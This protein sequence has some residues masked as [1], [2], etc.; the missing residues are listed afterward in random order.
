MRIGGFHRLQVFCYDDF[1]G[2][3]RKE[4]HYVMLEEEN[5][6][7]SHPPASSYFCRKSINWNF[8][9]SDKKENM[10]ILIFYEFT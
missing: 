3:L 9:K 6:S 4:R 2:V 1:A 10:R 7:S 5:R 8:A